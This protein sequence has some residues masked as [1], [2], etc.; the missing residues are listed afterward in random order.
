MK[1]ALGSVG[2][3]CLFAFVFSLFI[4]VLAASP[5]HAQ[6]G[7]AD[8]N[9]FIRLVAPDPQ[10]VIVAKKPLIAMAFTRQMDAQNLLVMLDGVD[11]TQVLSRAA[12]GFTFEPIQ[13]LEPGSHTL[14][15]SVTAPEG[16]PLYQ[17]FYFT[18]RH[19]ERFEKAYSRN[20]LTVLAHN[21][22]AKSDSL[23]GQVPQRRVDA[24][25]NTLSQLKEGGLDV[26]VNANIKYV[27]QD[28]PILPPEKEGVDLIDV[29][30]TADYTRGSVTTHAEAGDTLVDLSPNTLSS[31]SRRGAQLSIGGS[32][33]KVGGFTVNSAQTYGYDGETGIDSDTDSHIHGVYGDLHLLESRL[34]MRAIYTRGGEE[35]DSFG[36]TATDRN[37]E[38]DTVGFILASDFFEGRLV[39]EFEAN[40]SR[41]DDDTTDNMDMRSDNAYRF[42][43]QGGIDRYTYGAT[44]KYFG[45]DYE[46][47]GNQGLEKDRQGVELNGGAGFEKHG[48]SLMF[49]QYKDN[50]DS[51]ETR[52]EIQTQ[53]GLIDYAYTGFQRVPITFSYQAERSESSREPDGT[54]QVDYAIDSF[55][56]SVSYFYNQW[57]IALQGTYAL[58]DDNTAQD[59]DTTNTLIALMPQ[60]FS[61]I[62]SVSPNLSYNKTRDHAAE[63]DTDVYT[64]SMEIQGRLPNNRF[65]YGLGGTLDFT[66]TSDDLVDQ[67]TTAYHFD[68][69]YE[70]G[71]FFKGGLVPAIGLR[72]ESNLVEDFANDVVTR[73]YVFMVTFSA[74][75]AA[76]F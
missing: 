74:S 19:H 23:D 20:Q 47:V 12:E 14:T 38:S 53:T 27:E 71:R 49:G 9:H 3:C 31:L 56:S 33:A 8:P 51:D 15:V 28:I 2:R 62:L 11:I 75:A 72:G 16:E 44:Y 52:P 76:S 65:R 63:I 10:H 69:A 37:A 48:L 42:N 66:S 17:E 46:V 6:D 59:A 64:I 1:A 57:N 43:V 73:D 70:L 68:L 40:F 41:F 58:M 50:V 29:L 30:V 39:S 21:A 7:S 67:R 61:E 35:G 32:L 4:M 36:T 25:L 34:R 13:V 24:N 18:T 55:S 26:A 22:F 5:L 60:Y 45:S 54:A